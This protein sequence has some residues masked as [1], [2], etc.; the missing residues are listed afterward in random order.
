MIGQKIIL[1]GVDG[2]GKT[3]IA[4][5][6]QKNNPEMNYRIV[7]C[8]KDTPNDLKYFL[9]L[10]LSDDNIIFDR[11]YVE[12]FVY[13][14][15]KQRELD[16]R[17]SLQELALVENILKDIN[18]RCVFID[19]P[20]DTCLINCL[21]D[22]FDNFYN[23]NYIKQLYDRYIYF[24]NYISSIDWEIYTNIFDSGDVVETN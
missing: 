15:A 3:T 14:D 9:N 19:T 2:C 17:L 23:L 22:E 12:Q 16:G 8:T 5:Q 24:I 7:H 6:I 21:K 18:C 1:T 20:L 11:L 4:Q 10:L 13:Q